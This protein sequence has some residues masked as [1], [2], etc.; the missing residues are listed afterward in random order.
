MSSQFDDA[1]DTHRPLADLAEGEE[2]ETTGKVW[3]VGAGPGDPGLITVRGWEILR[4]ADAVV[5][6]RLIPP[7]LLDACP[8]RAD[9]YDV[10]KFPGRQTVS[11]EEINALL[12]RLARAGKRVVRLKG[13]DPFVF[14]RGGEEALALAEAGVAWEEVPGV[15]AAIAAA[16]YAGV[17]VT[18]RGVA[19]SFAVLTGHDGLARPRVA[20]AD[21]LVI[22]MGIAQLH[23]IVG[24][25]LDLGRAP[26]EPAALVQMASTPLQR[27]V[28]APLQAIVEVARQ[29]PITSP[30]TL[31]VGHSVRLADRL[32]WFERRPLF[33]R[34]VLV[35][36]TRLQPSQLAADLRTHGADVVELPT[37]RSRPVDPGPLDRALRDLASGC[38]SWVVFGSPEIVA[39]VWERLNTLG[40]DSRA[41]RAR[42]C[43]CGP[44][45][46]EALR[47]RGIVPDW[48][49]PS[50]Y[51]SAAVSGLRERDVAGHDVFVPCLAQCEALGQEL[52]RIGARVC[53]VPVAQ[54]DS[55]TSR[56]EDAAQLRA[57][58]ECRSL[59]ALV[60]PASR[61]VEQIASLL[62]ADLKMVSSAA[63]VCIGPSTADTA[64]RLGLRVDS[65]AAN[66]TRWD[67][68]EAVV[69]LLTARPDPR[70][71]PLSIPVEGGE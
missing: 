12:V 27:T 37:L 4:S 20:D 34:R 45:T 26:E 46:V 31:I 49:C 28:R 19:E 55:E 14:G 44:R 30:A 42:V 47:Q 43:G 61:S 11:Q 59:D 2:A 1:N 35:A 40:M 57:F 13:G 50:S 32:S 6:D 17:P 71:S 18:H 68:I 33:G 51:V 70:P 3:L 60:F 41:V 65:I 64:R 29:Q 69:Q 53:A 54:L 24:R 56:S 25:L 21:T 48:N 5:Y 10:G 22:L 8:V 52:R 9:R 67:L 7:A 39:I 16:A 15:S 66:P 36:R 62:A 23:E 38:F 58:L 63:V